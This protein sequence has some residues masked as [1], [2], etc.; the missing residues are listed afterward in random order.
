MPEFLATIRLRQKIE[1]L[2]SLIKEQITLGN[3]NEAE[4]LK[5]IEL[6]KNTA[7]LKSALK[8]L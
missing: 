1:D 2:Y 8:F 6:V 5:I 3:I 4:L 7:R